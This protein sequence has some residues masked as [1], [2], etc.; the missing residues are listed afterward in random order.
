MGL[1][2]LLLIAK[3]LKQ[4]VG[5][6][7]QV[8]LNEDPNPT[9]PSQPAAPPMPSEAEEAEVE[10]RDRKQAFTKY[11]E[12]FK[13][14]AFAKNSNGRRSKIAAAGHITSGGPWK[15]TEGGMGQHGES[16]VG[17]QLSG[18]ITTYRQLI[19]ISRL[20]HQADKRRKLEKRLLS[21]LQVSQ[22]MSAR[23]D[24]QDDQRFIGDTAKFLSMETAAKPSMRKG[25]IA[26]AEGPLIN[27]LEVLSK[28]RE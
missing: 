9:M 6:V 20:K 14:Q 3:V 2:S 11:V 1:I 7:A 16:A 19:Q 8:D 21:L 18:L 26:D 4:R 17:G 28:E 24:L 10:L 27:A 25:V 12:A 23:H 5:M 15:G 22:K 13:S